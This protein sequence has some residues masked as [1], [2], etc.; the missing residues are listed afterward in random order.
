MVQVAVA[1][2]VAEGEEIQSI[3]TSAGIDSE[4]QAAGEDDPLT[5]VVPEMSL[6]AAQDA[7][8]ALTEPDDLIASSG[9]GRLDPRP[10]RAL[11]C[12]RPF[13]PVQRAG[14]ESGMSTHVPDR[15]AVKT[16]L[17]AE[18][19]A[20]TLSRI[21]HEII[22]RNDDLT[23]VALIGIH[24]RG[25]PIARAARRP[26]RGAERGGG[27]A[28][29]RRHHL[30]PRR[31]NPR[32]GSARSA[33]DEA[34]STCGDDLRTRRRRPLTGRTIRAAIETLFELGRPARIQLA[35]LVDRGH[36]GC[37]SGPTTSA[38]TCPLPREQADPGRARGDRRC[39]PDPPRRRRRRRRDE[40]PDLDR[41]P[42]PRRRRTVIETAAALADVRPRDCRR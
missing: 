19:L 21:A 8:E 29:R 2:D 10:P 41:R 6:E 11:G 22:E 23:K 9:S 35:V 34:T 5:V 7:I 33:R 16:L 4:L 14:K 42:H 28:R 39:R 1:G 30:P 15:T 37:R 3:L 38:R 32:P 31:H 25:V 18:A 13:N 12:A 20:R 36:R 17:D 24:T 26:D 40:A 27:R